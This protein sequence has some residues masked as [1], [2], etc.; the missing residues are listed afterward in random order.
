MFQ[1]LAVV[2]T[3]AGAVCVP[4]CALGWSSVSHPGA[5]RGLSDASASPSTR[6]ASSTTPI[7]RVARKYTDRAEVFVSST[8]LIPNRRLRSSRPRSSASKRPVGAL[9]SGSQPGLASKRRAAEPTYRRIRVVHTCG[10]SNSSR[11]SVMSFPPRRRAGASHAAHCAEILPS[12]SAPHAVQIHDV[13]S[14]T[15][16]SVA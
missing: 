1:S 13:A 6:F 8:T 9:G 12:T 2:V 15:R 7:V 4:R 14:T 5:A 3:R 11:S 16:T 10:T